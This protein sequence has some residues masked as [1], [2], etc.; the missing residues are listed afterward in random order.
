MSPSDSP[1]TAPHSPFPPSRPGYWVALII[2]VILAV[3]GLSL[4]AFG[5]SALAF[6]N[7]QRDGEYA[8][9]DL[10]TVQSTGH[11]I[12]GPPFNV[13][14]SGMSGPGVPAVAD[15]ASFRIEATSMLPDQEVFIGIGESSR[16]SEY[17]AGVPH[18]EVRD[19]AYG[20]ARQWP[21]SRAWNV[22]AVDRF[23]D[24]HATP[25]TPADQDFWEVSASGSGTQEISWDLASGDWLLVIM[26]A[27]ATRP[28][29]VEGSVGVRSDLAARDL[30][31]LG[32]GL[33]LAGLVS[34]ALGVLLLLIGATGLGRNLAAATA[35]PVR[36]GPYP[37]RLDADLSQ[38]PSRWLWL[39]KWLLAIPHFFVLALLG[40]SVL[41][42]TIAAGVGI[43]FTGRYPKSWF[44][45]TVG[46]L[47]W[48]W[49]VG[50]YSYSALAT[51]RYPPFTLASTDYPADF[52]VD[53]PERLS[54]G[55]VLVKWWLLA[56]PHYLI[57]GLFTGGTM[58]AWSYAA[59]A[60]MGR[61]SASVS[62]LG[63]LVL[64]IA[65][66]LLVT[67]RHH[68]GMADFALGINRWVYRVNT[69]A[70]L[71]R[72]EYPPLRLDQGAQEPAET[73]LADR[74]ERST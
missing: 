5:A 18:S 57:V 27:D 36:R 59:P 17:L 46:V 49:R 66:V 28:V 37:A 54:R 23:P 33:L 67:G 47:R 40:V 4:V 30:G 7:Y 11:A 70:L 31:P 22:D 61:M 2:G 29:W 20:G 51:D 41:F 12:V 21:G 69:Y 3:L 64:F 50:F 34:L 24:G 32:T 53:Y 74:R 63:L 8:S 1:V 6:Q 44:F 26:N 48:S 38:A 25:A 56:I 60:G 45:F 43:L 42:T 73:Q 58:V 52:R 55:L 62:V 9:T 68:R 71:L 16:V 10:S 13:N 39:V 15:L 19:V 72:D 14:L 35:P 65:V